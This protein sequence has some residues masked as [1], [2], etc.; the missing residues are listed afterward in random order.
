M[1]VVSEVAATAS[2]EGFQAIR[3][4]AAPDVANSGAYDSGP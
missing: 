2:L 3:I 1:V 4:L